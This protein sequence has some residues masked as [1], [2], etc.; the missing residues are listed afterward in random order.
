MLDVGQGDAILIRD[1]TR[2]LLI[3][4]GKSDAMLLK[5]LARQRVYHL[6]MVV[7]T[8]LDDDHC[9]ALSVLDGTIQVDH[10]C[11][12]LG[13]IEAQSE[14]ATIQAAEKLLRSGAPESLVKGDMLYL[15]QHISLLVIWPEDMVSKGANED[16]ICLCLFYDADGDSQPEFTAL[17]TGDAESMVLDRIIGD[18]PGEQFDIFKVGHHGSKKAVTP[19][20]IERM[21][22]RIALISV[23][24]DNRYGHPS[25]DTINT[26]EAA[27]VV[28]YRTDLNGDIVLVFEGQRLVVRC[29]TMNGESNSF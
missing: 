22:V 28:I 13:L 6:D 9:G 3:D 20:Q 27:A 12:A 7:I 23:G 1:G 29:D 19:S 8:H 21:A 11:F 10:V 16:S 18:V 5:A 25:S 4:T 15:S 17:F 14:N 2:N 24:K 26:L